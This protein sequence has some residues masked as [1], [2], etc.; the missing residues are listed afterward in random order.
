MNK[1]LEQ[2]NENF[3]NN[4][5]IQW[6]DTKGILKINENLKAV[7]ILSTLRISEHYEGYKI[8]IVNKNGGKVDSIFLK[9]KDNLK[10]RVDNRPDYIGDFEIIEY[11][12]CDWYIAQP[13]RSDIDLMVKKIMKYINSWK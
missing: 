11:C 9:F 10:T 3:F 1:S 4:K 12:Q 7:I 5:K 13:S 8:S 6:Y 2:F